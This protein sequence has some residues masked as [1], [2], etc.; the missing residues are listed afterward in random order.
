MSIAWISK[1]LWSG[2]GKIVIKTTRKYDETWNSTLSG[3]YMY[4]LSPNILS[5]HERCDTIR[6]ENYRCYRSY[7]CRYGEDSINT[8]GRPKKNS[9]VSIEQRAKSK[10]VKNWVCLK[11]SLWYGN[12]ELSHAIF[13]G[14]QDIRHDLVRKQMY[15][16]RR[17]TVLRDR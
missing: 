16:Q 11:T 5:G 17:R 13:D 1:R 7:G 12:C 2:D 10:V 9:I 8:S 3:W 4:L 14:V 6:F 15:Q